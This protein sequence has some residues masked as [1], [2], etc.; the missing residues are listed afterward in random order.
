MAAIFYLSSILLANLLVIKFGIIHFGLTFPAGAPII[1]LTFSARDF[2]HRRYGDRAVW[3]FMILGCILTMLLSW[4]IALASGSAFLIAE[5]ID[6]AIYRFTG[7]TFKQRIILSNIVSTPIDS[8]SFVLLA[9]GWNWSAIW[10]QTLIKFASSL[11]VIPVLWVI[12][13]KNETG[14]IAI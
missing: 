9:F 6:Y 11:I 10:G 7:K 5:S 3:V 4:R 2:V 13:R 12:R 1:G 8:A 14:D